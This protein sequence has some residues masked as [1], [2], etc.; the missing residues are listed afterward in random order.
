LEVSISA[1]GDEGTAEDDIKEEEEP[2]E[3]Q[4]DGVSITTGLTLVDGWVAGATVP[5]LG[6]QGGDSGYLI[7]DGTVIHQGGK[8]IS[9]PVQT[10]EISLSETVTTNFFFLNNIQTKAGKR[11]AVEFYG[12]EAGSVIFKGISVQRQEENKWDVTYVFTW[13]AWSHMRQVPKRD[14]DGN[15]EFSGTDLPV[16]YKQPFPDTIPFDFA[17]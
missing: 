9:V 1:L 7:N 6:S 11:N 5:A 15:P 14:N 3:R 4:F 10:T 17:P 12:F 2:E 16:Y 13:D 8:P